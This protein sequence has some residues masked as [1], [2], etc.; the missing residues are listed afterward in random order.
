MKCAQITWVEIIGIG[1]GTC[2]AFLEAE[3]VEATAELK[4]ADAGAL[5]ESKI[6]AALGGMQLVAG[7]A[8][9]LAAT[10]FM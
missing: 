10:Y 8:A 4:G 7:S 1:A 6:A 9:A 3:S 2:Q 5:G